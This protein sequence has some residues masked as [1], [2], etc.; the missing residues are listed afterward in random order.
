[1]SNVKIPKISMSEFYRILKSVQCQ[2][3]EDVYFDDLPQSPEEYGPVQKEH[4]DD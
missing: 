3:D 4:G 2:E 1:M